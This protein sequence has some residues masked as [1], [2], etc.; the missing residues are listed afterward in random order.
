MRLFAQKKGYSLSDHGLYPVLRAHRN[1]K[2]W[3]GDLIPCYTEL[4]VFQKLNVPYKT[5]E[6]RSV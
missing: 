3:K 2:V 4:E 6:E 5:P 1:E